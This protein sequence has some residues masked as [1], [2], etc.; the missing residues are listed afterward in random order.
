[1]IHDNIIIGGRYLRPLRSSVEEWKA[2]RSRGGQL[3]IFTIK[4]SAVELQLCYSW[5]TL[6]KVAKK[7]DVPLC[8]NSNPFNSTQ[9]NPLSQTLTFTL[10]QFVHFF[11]F[12]FSISGTEGLMTVG[13]GW[14]QEL[15]KSGKLT[16]PVYDNDVMLDRPPGGA[17]ILWVERRG[18]W[19]STWAPENEAVWFESFWC[20]CFHFCGNA[21]SDFT[22]QGESRLVEI[23]IKSQGLR[24]GRPS[25]HWGGWDRFSHA[26]D[27]VDRLVIVS[28][29]DPAGFSHLRE[30][31]K[32]PVSTIT[33]MCVNYHMR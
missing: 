15:V 2:W 12:F 31:N 4:V 8:R 7:D 20:P 16:R 26:D 25:R 27:I 21:A 3:I 5:Q 33:C 30:I 10:E 22:C 6:L 23:P 19:S 32:Q 14:K 28:P 11:F 17:T 9:S 24:T 18:M 13:I 1:M 29:W